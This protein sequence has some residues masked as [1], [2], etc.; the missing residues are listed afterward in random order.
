MTMYIALWVAGYNTSLTTAH[1]CKGYRR[2]SA[3]NYKEMKTCAVFGCSVNRKMYKGVPSYKSHGY[4]LHAEK[5]SL[6]N[7]PG[8]VDIIFY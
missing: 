3:R 4:I 1:A 5:I 6:K 8:Y 2:Y 7:I